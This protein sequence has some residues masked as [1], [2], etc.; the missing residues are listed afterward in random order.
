MGADCCDHY[1]DKIIKIYSFRNL[2]NIELYC[3]TNEN[4][5]WFEFIL[6]IEL[7]LVFF[8]VIPMR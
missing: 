4:V 8:N 5:L 1:T 2:L 3:Y 6:L 7:N